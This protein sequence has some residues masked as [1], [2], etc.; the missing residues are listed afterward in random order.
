[1]KTAGSF[2]IGAF[3]EGD[4]FLHQLDPRL[5]IFLLLGLVA[6]LFSATSPLRLVVIFL[7]WL[8]AARRCSSALSSS[9]RVLYWM[10]WLLLFTLLL[11]LFFTPGRT[12][13]GTNWLSYDGWLRGLMVD[14]QVIL[15]LLFSLLLSWT[16][17]PSELAWGLAR[18][19]SPLSRLR[20]PIEEFGGMLLL[21]L[22]F[23][24][25]IQTEL[26][27][28]DR[29]GPAKGS[30]WS[31]KIQQRVGL[32][33]PLLFRLVD[34]ADQL[35]RQIVSGDHPLPLDKE[36]AEGRIRMID[37]FLLLTGVLVLA[38]LWRL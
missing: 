35:A 38:G 32:I 1:M 2:D 5:K 8:M 7:L 6:C 10:R 12:L 37:L 9:L 33:E 23:F 16:T 25:L 11:H 3:R 15:A 34:R 29:E 13:F 28:L 20:L 24:P 27:Q 26:A 19:L 36:V 17:R 4:S 31:S 18:L 30:G 14:A 22:H 21:V